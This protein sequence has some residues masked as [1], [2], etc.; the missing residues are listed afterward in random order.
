MQAKFS[1]TTSV[2]KNWI[3]VK[4]VVMSRSSSLPFSL[5]YALLSAPTK[6]LTIILCTH[7]SDTLTI[8]TFHTHLYTHSPLHSWID[9][10][11][12][13][14]PSSESPDGPSPLPDPEVPEPYTIFEKP[15]PF[16]GVGGSPS[17]ENLGNGCPPEPQNQVTAIGDDNNP[18]KSDRDSYY[19]DRYLIVCDTYYIKCNML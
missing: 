13:E 10:Y 17:Q 6:K 19:S 2:G 1:N 15:P 8:L 12:D 5:H 16:G 3:L 18:S 11:M 14:L 9:S 7:L 4:C